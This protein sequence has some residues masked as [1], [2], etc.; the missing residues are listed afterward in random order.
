M[1][2]RIHLAP[3]RTFDV[4]DWQ[5]T[6]ADDRIVFTPSA[7]NFYRQLWVT[8]LA[9]VVTGAMWWV[10]GL[11][12]GSAQLA[13]K[14]R[15][16]DRLA[17]QIDQ[18]ER[19]SRRLSTSA[20][21]SGPRMSEQYA[22]RAARL[23]DDLADL[24]AELDTARPT[25]GAAY[26]NLYWGVFT[27][28]VVLG[29]GLPALC[30]VVRAELRVDGEHVIF[31]RRLGRTRRFP[32]AA[33]VGVKPTARRLATRGGTDTP[34]ADRG[35]LW[36]LNLVADAD[37]PRRPG[38]PPTRSVVFRVELSPTLPARDTILPNSV[39]NIAR[40][41][42]RH[43]GLTCSPASTTDVQNET[44]TGWRGVHT[45]QLKTRHA[46]DVDLHGKPPLP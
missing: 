22:D 37:R 9:A 46:R 5:Q 12:P 40:L 32:V 29:L 34:A 11:P 21:P 2:E 36:E 16:A 19:Q 18:A 23:R 28:A 24:R 41:L 20:G 17:Q 33:F 15:Q 25:L 8:L 7:T 45:K 4:C 43:A 26:D 38:D 6:V 14:Q 30:L 1:R 13:A 42:E 27:L 31:S 3:V 35:W 10:W 44:L 39:A